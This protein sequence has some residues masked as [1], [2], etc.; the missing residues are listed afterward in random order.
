MD[1]DRRRQEF[2]Q[3]L[4]AM[5]FQGQAACTGA[6]SGVELDW[7]VFERG[8]YHTKAAELT[9]HFLLG[10]VD[11]TRVRR[12]FF[13]CWPI[14]SP[15]QAREFR[16]KAFRWLDEIRHE[17]GWPADVPVRRSYVD[18]CRGVR[19]EAV[20]WAL[21]FVA[22]HAQLRGLGRPLA[23]LTAAERST[24]Q[25]STGAGAEAVRL[26]L[27]RSRARYGRCTRDRCQ[28]VG[29]WRLAEDA[30]RRQI[31]AADDGREKAHAQYRSCRKRLAAACPT[32]EVPDVDASAADV[33]RRLAA[34]VAQA[35][36]LWGG[37]AGWVEQQLGTVDTV[38]SVIECRANSVRLDAR[39][40]VR[41]APAPAMADAWAK[42]LA[43]GESPFKAADVSLHAVAQMAS[44]CVGVLR[45]SVGSPGEPLSLDGAGACELP[46]D[47]GRMEELDLAI[48]AQDARL[49]RLRRLR[50]Q[51][52]EQR[53]SVAQ[54]VRPV[55][56]ENGSEVVDA[57]LAGIRR[58]VG[59]CEAGGVSEPSRAARLAGMWDDLLVADGPPAHVVDLAWPGR[60]AVVPR[61]SLSFM[62]DAGGSLFSGAMK[63]HSATNRSDALKRLRLQG[64]E[65]DVP[66]FLV[67]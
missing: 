65:D 19:F 20:L 55:C 9:L 14:G 33:E 50:A 43:K 36:R 67:G 48:G 23:E 31:A 16:A 26:A 56:S 4:L 64:V 22:A 53:A 61:L 45:R 38:D 52:A 35:E 41:L 51:L 27:G 58:P 30:L 1:D 40:D 10:R 54:I 21:A 39:R 37:S 57:L 8:I 25:L 29:Q 6:Y 60:Q 3:T 11:A 46:V 49:A 62:S 47:A 63:R 13:D 15:Q 34:L 32:A 17:P 44:A 5:G 18:E 24:G 12:E 2:W 28:A 7:R 42:W 66:D 59:K